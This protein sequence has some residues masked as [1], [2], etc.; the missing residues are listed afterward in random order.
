MLYVCYFEI[1]SVSLINQI[2][3][4]LSLK[5]PLDR[6]RLLW[7]NEENNGLIELIR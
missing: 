2:K 6:L 3:M 4:K 7:Y 1:H 5:K